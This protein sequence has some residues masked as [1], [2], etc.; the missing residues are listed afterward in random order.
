MSIQPT[1]R[2]LHTEEVKKNIVEQ[3]GRLFSEYG[4]DSTGMNDI[5]KAAGV[6]TGALY[7][8]FKNKEDILFAVFQNRKYLDPKILEGFKTSED[9]EEDLEKFLCEDMVDQVLEDG[10]DFTRYRIL[11]VFKFF[12]NSVMDQCVVAL[13]RRCIEKKIFR[14]DIPA[15]RAADF[16]LSVHRG[17]V[18]QYAASEPSVD[19]KALVKGRYELAVLA[20]KTSK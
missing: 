1:K 10:Y 15:E 2:K 14:D 9:P 20:L 8:H 6:T 12:P 13:C 19:L 11:K 4:Y 17:A 5:A 7:H 18:Y 3:A 16:L